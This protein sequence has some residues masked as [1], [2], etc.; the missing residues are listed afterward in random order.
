MKPPI[1]DR[2]YFPPD[3][4]VLP[5]DATTGLLPWSW[6]ERRLTESHN[7]WIATC[8][9]QG[10]PHLMVV[11]GVWLD[12]A[13]WFSTGPHSRKMKNLIA[14]PE[15]VIGTEDAEETVILEG[16]AEVIRDGEAQKRFLAAY[17]PKYGTGLV[18]PLIESGKGL[19]LRV[20][21]LIAFGMDEHAENFAE[22]MTRWKFR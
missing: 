14:H 17:D 6:A 8:R 21:P 12:G 20:E 3:A 10:T 5:R 11:W 22:A 19:V 1:A 7:Y 18:A 15:C 4:A 16:T 13:F 9:P 2:P